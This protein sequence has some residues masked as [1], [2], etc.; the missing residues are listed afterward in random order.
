MKQVC[1]LFTMLLFASL[2]IAQSSKISAGK[3]A[4]EEGNYSKAYEYLKSAS[5]HKKT[6]ENAETWALYAQAAAGLLQSTNQDILQSMGITDL[7]QESVISLIKKANNMDSEAAYTSY[8]QSAAETIINQSHNAGVIAYNDQ[9]DFEAAIKHFT[10]KKELMQKLLPNPP[11][12]TIG[13]VVIGSAHLQLG[14]EAEGIRF[15]EQLI[16]IKYNDLGVYNTVINYYKDIDNDD[17]YLATLKKAQDMYPSENN[18]TL[19]E[20]DYYI[21][22]GKIDEKMEELIAAAESNP[23]NAN[24]ALIISSVYERKEDYKKQYEWANKALSVAPDEFSPNFNTAVSLYNQAVSYNSEMNFMLSDTSAEY[25]QAKKNR[26]E[27]AKQSLPYFEKAYEID[28]NHKGVQQ[29]LYFYHKMMGNKDLEQKFKT[30]YE[31]E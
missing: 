17:A 24:L 29:A 16:D 31:Q 5:E 2:S 28:P 30:L 20:L 6:I 7:N 10:E 11:F 15:Y 12:D 9:Q 18:F 13:I 21:Q 23:D 3:T 27:L 26:D 4:L 25:L 19:L 22:K 14:N 8:T 1:I